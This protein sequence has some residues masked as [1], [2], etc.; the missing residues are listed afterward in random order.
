MKLKGL[1]SDGPSSIAGPDSYCNKALSISPPRSSHSEY[2]ARH[3]LSSSRSRSHSPLNR[4]PSTL[5]TNL[6]IDEHVGD[7]RDSA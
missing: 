2:P 1:P 4:L 7:G 5:S 6:N 3:A